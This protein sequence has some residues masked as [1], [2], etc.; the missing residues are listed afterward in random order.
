MAKTLGQHFLNARLIENASDPTNR[1][2][3]DKG[4]WQVTPKGKYMIQDFSHRA[5]VS[6]SHMR[7]SLSRIESFKIFVFERLTDDDKL[8]FA[9]ANLTA[10]FQVKAAAGRQK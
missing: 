7:E 2:M 9:R 8:A 5:H 3:R 4:V 6:T 10:A 1:T